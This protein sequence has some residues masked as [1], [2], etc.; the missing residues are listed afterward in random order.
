M[1]WSASSFKHKHN[2][3]LSSG[4]SDKAAQIANSVLKR[5]GDEGKAIKIANAAVRR[6]SSPAKKTPSKKETK[7]NKRKRS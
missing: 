2:K 5:T 3:S 1:P 4:Q 6:V 7:D